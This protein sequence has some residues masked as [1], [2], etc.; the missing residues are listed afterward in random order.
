MPEVRC[1]QCNTITAYDRIRKVSYC[2]N[3]NCN[4]DLLIRKL[5]GKT[6]PYPVCQSCESNPVRSPESRLCES[7]VDEFKESD[8]D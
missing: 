4:V 8:S 2:R 1:Y 5:G 6:V 7:C 3:D